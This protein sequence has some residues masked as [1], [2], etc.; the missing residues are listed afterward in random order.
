M[1]IIQKYLLSISYES[2]TG[3]DVRDMI[4][5]KKK[6][7]AKQKSLAYIC[8]AYMLGRQTNH[9]KNKW[10]KIVINIMMEVEVEWCSLE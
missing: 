6:K 7:K 1:H 8:R 5:N 9:V 4:V 2:G 10:I 3:L